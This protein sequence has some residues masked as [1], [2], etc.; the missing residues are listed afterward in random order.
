MLSTHYPSLKKGR[1]WSRADK[2]WSDEW[3]V[4]VDSCVTLV[5]N[6]L[7]TGQRIETLS[8]HYTCPTTRTGASKTTSS[9]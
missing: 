2:P 5:A 8:Y 9:R 1:R 6:V 4:T 3:T 7:V